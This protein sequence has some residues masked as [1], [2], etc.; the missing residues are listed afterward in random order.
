[1][2]LSYNLKGQTDYGFLPPVSTSVVAEARS[3]ICVP[4][5][6]TDR[7]W[8]HSKSF[9]LQLNEAIDAENATFGKFYP[10]YVHPSYD[11]NDAFD[12]SAKVL[13]ELRRVYQGDGIAD[14]D[15]EYDQ[16]VIDMATDHSCAMDLDNTFCHTCPSDGSFGQRIV[17]RI[18]DGCYSSGTEN[19]AWIS[20]SDLEQSI[21]RIIY[22]MMYADVACCN[23]GHRENFLKCTYDDNT[24]I[25]FGIIR[26]DIQS[27]SGAF[28]DSWIM[29]WDYVTYR[30]YPNCGEGCN[31][32]ISIGTPLCSA[33]SG[34]VLPVSLHSFEANQIS[35]SEVDIQ[36]STWSES[37]H[38][39]FNLQRS[40]DGVDWTDIA[41]IKSTG[42][43][44][45]QKE[46][47][48]KDDL[49]GTKSKKIYYRLGQFDI[50]GTV[51][52]SDVV[53]V[54]A[55]C[56][57]SQLSIFPNPAGTYTNIQ[58]DV[59]V[60]SIEL[61]DTSGRSIKVKTEDSLKRIDTTDLDTGLYFLRIKTEDGHMEVL[62]F[63]KQ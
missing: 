63:I 44:K 61:Y 60:S 52:Y 59:R 18:G 51:E 50:D 1:M 53:V 46:Y 11:S 38:D 13:K 30:S 57:Q 39:H 47:Q 23:N 19:I 21:L 25:G 31:C 35:C 4:N 24:K 33:T 41:S 5:P 45:L 6:T 28:V 58:S 37:N 29:T 32:N 2:L 20:T 56:T 40:E 8:D 12:I 42:D 17:N 16:S 9:E 62:K 34:I 27:S 14:I 15:I 36:W 3:S 7:Q 26:G 49:S 48:F 54:Q 43:S 22:L 10:N 55:D